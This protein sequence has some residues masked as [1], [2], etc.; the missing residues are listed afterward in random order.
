MLWLCITWYLKCWRYLIYGDILIVPNFVNTHQRRL[1]CICSKPVCIVTKTPKC[2]VGC[3]P[4]W[5]CTEL[6]PKNYLPWCFCKSGVESLRFYVWEGNT[7]D[8]ESLW[9]LQLTL[10]LFPAGESWSTQD[11]RWGKIVIIAPARDKK[12][13]YFWWN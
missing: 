6:S 11:K 10:A 1:S 3:F 5:V 9:I 13:V 8:H 12:I 2:F 7:W 4:D